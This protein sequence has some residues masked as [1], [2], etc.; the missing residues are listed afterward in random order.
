MKYIF[1]KGR[2]MKNIIYIL[3]A[4]F[5]LSSCEDDM[6]REYIP[7]TMV[8]AYLIVNQPIEDV[9]LFTSQPVFDKYDISKSAIHDAEVYIRTGDDLLKLEIDPNSS[10]YYY[11]DKTYLVKP[12]THYDLEIV[13][14]DGT[15]ITGETNTPSEMNWVMEANDTIQYP[16]DTLH[17][18]ATDYISWTKV[19][20]VSYYY[21]NI[22]CL[23]TLNYGK[24]LTPA[25]D[26]PNRR[27]Y[28]FMNEM[29]DGDEYKEVSSGV[30]LGAQK[31]SVVWNVFRWFGPHAVTIYA[32][33][34]NMLKWVIQAF[35]MQ[36]YDERLSSVKNA[37]GCFGSA[38]MIS[39]TIFLRKNQR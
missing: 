19:P 8:E 16:L 24:Y 6:L 2:I 35:N 37:C 30:L 11:P 9:K 36:G 34:A 32:P 17:L 25:T 20:D 13:L 39:D 7:Q 33:D 38:S 23:D 29:S 1:R 3:L 18:R 31:T 22:K 27:V 14:K 10:S 28:N 4:L 26:E 15:V 21:G 12:N 5:A